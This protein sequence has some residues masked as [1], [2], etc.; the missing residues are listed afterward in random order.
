MDGWDVLKEKG[1]LTVVGVFSVWDEYRNLMAKDEWKNLGFSEQEVQVEAQD[2]A[3][4]IG[5]ERKEEEGR[6]FPRWREEH[7]KKGGK[8]TD[9]SG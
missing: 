4:R 9:V 3:Q 8:G 1:L 7:E 5:E 2:Q 6:E